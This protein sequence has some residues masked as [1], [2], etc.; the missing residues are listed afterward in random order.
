MQEKELEELQ[1]KF[2]NLT[3]DLINKLKEY[4]NIDSQLQ[5]YNVEIKKLDAKIK[6]I[7]Y[8]LKQRELRKKEKE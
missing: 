8:L 2:L 6:N 3:Y 5:K 7:E 4:A 1:I